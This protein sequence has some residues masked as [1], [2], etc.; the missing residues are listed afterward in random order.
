MQDLSYNTEYYLVCYADRECSEDGDPIDEIDWRTN[1]VKKFYTEH[2]AIEY[3]RIWLKNR[4]AD[5]QWIAYLY[6]QKV[7]H[8]LVKN[9][10]KLMAF[11]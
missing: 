11:T 7:T 8:S 9:F 6:V 1:R 4:E 10:D 2:E 3:A 5:Q